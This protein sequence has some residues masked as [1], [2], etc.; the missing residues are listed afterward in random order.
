MQANE[1]YES[2][3][4]CAEVIKEFNAELRLV[5]EPECHVLAFKI[6]PEWI[7]QQGAIYNLLNS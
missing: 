5:A 4:K 1:I 6:N 7:P 3:S 2:T